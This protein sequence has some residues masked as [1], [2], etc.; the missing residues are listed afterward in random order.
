MQLP[1]FL[2]T[3]QITIKIISQ[4]QSQVLPTNKIIPQQNL[5]KFQFLIHHYHKQRCNFTDKPSHLNPI[6]QTKTRNLKSRNRRKREKS[7]FNLEDQEEIE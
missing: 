4:L 6:T 5:P 1:P 7:E 2:N 3:N